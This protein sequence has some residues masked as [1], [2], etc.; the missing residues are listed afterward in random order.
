LGGEPLL[1]RNLWKLLDFLKSKQNLN[2]ELAI[3]SNLN[4]STETVQHC[5]ESMKELILNK[6]IKKADIQCSL[7]CWG[8]QQEFIRYGLDLEQWKHN[9][10]YLIQHKWLT[11]SIHQVVSSLSI[12]T[13][14]N[15]QQ[16]VAEWK[17]INPRI[18]QEYFTVDGPNQEVFHPEIFGKDFF[19]KELESIANNFVCNNEY[20]NF[21]KNRLLGIITAQ[22]T[23]EIDTTRLKKFLLTL[24]QI[25]S[26][27]NTNWRTLW[28]EIEQFFIKENIQA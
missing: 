15:L 16:H 7:D 18:S 8:P 22:S 10:E 1:Q 27:R 21:T 26:R 14:N 11:L 13:I 23:S 3:N 28:P 12:K 9:F 24:N 2:L 25:D 5:V 4:S 19:A 20:D 17:K 6:S